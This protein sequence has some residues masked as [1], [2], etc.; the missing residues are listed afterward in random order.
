MIL[1]ELAPAYV[2]VSTLGVYHCRLIKGA[3]TLPSPYDCLRL[4]NSLSQKGGYTQGNNWYT[5]MYFKGDSLYN[6]ICY[7]RKPPI[8]VRS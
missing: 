5:P 7:L 6:I 3:H 8:Q 1:Y 4:L 2:M